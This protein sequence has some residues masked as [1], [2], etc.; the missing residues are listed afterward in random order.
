[1][2]YIHTAIYRHA[3]MI[4]CTVY[5]THKLGK[6]LFNFRLSGVA[7]RVMLVAQI[8]PELRRSVSVMELRAQDAGHFDKPLIPS[9]YDPKLT[10]FNSDR[11][12][13]AVGFEEID[14]KRYYQGWWFQWSVSDPAV[15]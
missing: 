13:M 14:G 4:H 2:L 5:R 10:A 9:L 15:G 12:M 6:A 7:G 3:A 1:M 11:G 8:H